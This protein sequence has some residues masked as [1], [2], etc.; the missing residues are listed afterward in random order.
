MENVRGCGYGWG[1]SLSFLHQG[2]HD[3]CFVVVYEHVRIITL[4]NKLFR[5]NILTNHMRLA[6]SSNYSPIPGNKLVY[7]LRSWC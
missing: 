2:Q 5:K 6:Q 7:E 3:L 4:Q 1:L